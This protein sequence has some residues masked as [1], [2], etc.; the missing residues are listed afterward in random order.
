[1]VLVRQQITLTV[2]SSN[3][4]NLSNR[5]CRHN[6]GRFAH[7]PR[8]CKLPPISTPTS[9]KRLP[10]PI[11]LAPRA[12]PRPGSSAAN[13]LSALTRS[14]PAKLTGNLTQGDP[15]RP[16]EAGR[17]EGTL[18]K[19]ANGLRA[20]LDAIRAA[21]LWMDLLRACASAKQPTDN[22][23]TKNQ[24][25]GLGGAANPA[26]RGRVNCTRDADIAGSTL[27]L[28]AECC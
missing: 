3:F 7:L 23:D 17:A 19:S 16:T 1:M 18:G 20:G 9:K 10:I 8:H 22:R 15:G 13:P 12:Q 28:Q 24:E 4:L 27:F 14:T 2:T 5:Y 21:N 26:A 6:F 11:P 25:L